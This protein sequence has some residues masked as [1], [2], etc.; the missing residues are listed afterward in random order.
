MS[1]DPFERIY[2]KPE[3]FDFAKK[4]IIANILEPFIRIDINTGTFNPVSQ[5]WVKQTTRT[6][7]M[8]YLLARLALSTA[9]SEFPN[10]ASTKEVEDSTELP[11]G[12][13]R[14]KLRELIESK[15]AKQTEDGFYY[16]PATWLSINNAKAL[17]DKEV[18][19]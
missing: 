12:T 4:E 19:E 11:G 9:N 10:K 6:K 8:I 7:V 3:E 18:K 16:I 13:V 14:P 15:I 1:E 5:G 2:A 17:F